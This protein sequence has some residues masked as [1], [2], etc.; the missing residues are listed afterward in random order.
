MDHSIY[1]YLQKKKGPKKLLPKINSTPRRCD[2]LTSRHSHNLYLT[3]YSDTSN[4]A[5]SSV[6]SDLSSSEDGSIDSAAVLS[7]L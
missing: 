3:L 1:S 4:P 5:V 2:S 6:S 7:F